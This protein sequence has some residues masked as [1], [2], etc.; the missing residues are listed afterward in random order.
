MC[1][2]DVKSH[3]NE[4]LLS[5]VMA[6]SAQMKSFEQQLQDYCIINKECLEQGVTK[7]EMI[8]GELGVKNK[9]LKSEI[10]ALKSKPTEIVPTDMPTSK[11][12]PVTHITGTF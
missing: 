3:V 2:K 5:H 10:E 11:Q 4:K 9:R 8:V 7:L 6:Q 12:Q 1:C